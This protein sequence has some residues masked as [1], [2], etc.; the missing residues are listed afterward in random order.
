MQKYGLPKRRHS[1]ECEA[2]LMTKLDITTWSQ[3]DGTWHTSTTDCRKIRASENG[4]SD[5]QRFFNWWSSSQTRQFG[6]I[7]RPSAIGYVSSH[8]KVERWQRGRSHVPREIPATTAW[9]R[10]CHVGGSIAQ[11]CDYP[12]H[13]SRVVSRQA[14]LLVPVTGTTFAGT[15]ASGTTP[16]GR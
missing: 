3:P 5:M 1:L 6:C 16:R 15:T 4:P 7:G 14:S 2:L 13:D 11:G 12:R 9:R 8:A 10:P